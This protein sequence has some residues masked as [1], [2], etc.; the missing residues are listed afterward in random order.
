M[1]I[2]VEKTV[3]TF[4]T[5]EAIQSRWR[6][7]LTVNGQQLPYDAA[8]T[9]LGVTLDW[10]LRFAAHA[11]KVR[12][13][14]TKRLNLL[15]A[16]RG[17]KWGCSRRIM[18]NLYNA[19]V[20]SVADYGGAA[21]MPAA[22]KTALDQV[23]TANRRAARII[24]GCLRSSPTELLLEE[25]DLMPTEHRRDQL[26]SITY[27]KALRLPEDNPRDRCA[28]QVQR[29][30]LPTQSSFRE[31]AKALGTGERLSE[32]PREPLRLVPPVPP[33]KQTLN[34]TLSADL[35]RTTR[36]AD[37]PILKRL[38]AENTLRQLRPADTVI[39]T[40]G[41]AQNGHTNGG[42]G[43]I[44]MEDAEVLHEA[45]GPAG[46]RCSSYRAELL[47]LRAA[48]R[49]LELTARQ[50]QE[51]RIC[52]D[53]RSTV[54][55]LQSGPR[56]T[57]DGVVTEIWQLIERMFPAD[58]ALL[59]IQ[60]IPGHCGM[61]GNEAADRLAGG[62][63]NIIGQQ[64]VPVD[65]SSAKAAVKRRTKERWKQSIAPTTMRTRGRPVERRRRNSQ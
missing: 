59:T 43:F 42:Y 33:W 2:N 53:S 10:A 22:S 62:A 29:Q 56:S 45:N 44:A 31:H 60:W 21:W 64:Q 30:R 51:V 7:E 58:G 16:L 19:Y 54:Q 55:A 1:Q 6:P 49:W 14:M 24:T 15:S 57:T 39:W 46:G 18:R 47:A 12:S 17:T 63:S 50:V 65:F 27:E 9:F 48:L 26:C 11:K 36:R 32:L 3:T 40:D 20:R 13:K 35:L 28:T 8:P 4:F 61:D 23:D 38:T 41:A 37:D 5:T 34:V 25:A 52:T